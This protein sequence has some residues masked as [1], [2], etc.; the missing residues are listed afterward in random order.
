MSLLNKF[1][2]P[3]TQKGWEPLSSEN[4]EKHLYITCTIFILNKIEQ[5]IWSRLKYEKLQKI[6]MFWNFIIIFLKEQKTC[7][8]QKNAIVLIVIWRLG[9]LEKRERERQREIERKR[10]RESDGLLQ[11]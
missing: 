2:V 10:E 3:R 5:F 9:D 1:R 11:Q 6:H 7:L 8:A 4:F